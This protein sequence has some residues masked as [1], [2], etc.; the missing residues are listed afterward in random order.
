[1][2]KNDIGVTD[3]FTQLNVFQ[4][5][6]CVILD[7]TTYYLLHTSHFVFFLEQIRFRYSQHI[8]SLL[9]SIVTN[10][11]EQSLTHYG[12]VIFRLF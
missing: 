1:M 12:P 5:F 8:Q 7:Y 10:L 9:P 3:D 2:L 4:N 6:L 11:K